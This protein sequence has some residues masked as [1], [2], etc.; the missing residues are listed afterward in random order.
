EADQ[1]A[2]RLGESPAR[3]LRKLE[4]DRALVERRDDLTVELCALYNQT[5]RSADALSLIGKRRFQPWEGGEGLAL[6][7]HART[8]LLLGRAALAA[9]NPGEARARFQAA[10][11]APE[12]LG[13]ARHLLANQSDVHLWLGEAC[14]AG[15]DDTA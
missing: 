12:N 8:H 7:Q 1:L 15:G 10:L 2:K 6:G 14:A 11:A 13:E 9:G 4:R 5:G 3:R